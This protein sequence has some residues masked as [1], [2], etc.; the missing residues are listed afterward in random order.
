MDGEVDVRRQEIDGEVEG[1]TTGGRAEKGTRGAESTEEM[2]AEDVTEKGTPRWE[3]HLSRSPQLPP[4]LPAPC[5]LSGEE[6]ASCF[7]LVGLRE[8]ADPR[9][10][11]R[12]PSWVPLLLQ[13][14]SPG[15]GL[16][17]TAG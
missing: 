1:R 8:L 7:P 6:G 12:P 3:C 10:G 11:I 4:R 9:T 13:V 17:A 5:W 16:S 2:G 14:T 15:R